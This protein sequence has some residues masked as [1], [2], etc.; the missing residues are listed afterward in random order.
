LTL[1]EVM[2]TV[3]TKHNKVK[4]ESSTNQ[5][6]RQTTFNVKAESQKELDKA[7]RS[8]LAALSPVVSQSSPRSVPENVNCRLRLALLSMHH[9]PLFPL[10]SV[11]K[12]SNLSD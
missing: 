1:G 8:L 4:I 2:K 11:L 9:S 6:T 3:M 10:S 7:K 12:V 5:R